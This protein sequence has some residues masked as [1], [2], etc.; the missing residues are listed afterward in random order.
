MRLKDQVVLVPGGGSGAGEA[1][2]A[3]CIDEGAKVLAMGRDAAKLE[4]ACARAG[5]AQVT[6]SIGGRR[7]SL[8]GAS[9]I[10]WDDMLERMQQTSLADMDPDLIFGLHGPGDG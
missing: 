1:I 7:D 8:R 4:A 6:V 10:S 5:G 9:G 3:A 2:V